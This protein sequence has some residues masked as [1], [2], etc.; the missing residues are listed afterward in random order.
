MAVSGRP[1]VLAGPFREA[2]FPPPGS[3]HRAAGVSGFPQSEGSQREQGRNCNAFYD[4][5]SEVTIHH[6]HH[7]LYIRNKQITTSEEGGSLPEGRIMGECVDVFLNHHKGSFRLSFRDSD[8]QV[9]IPLR[10]LIHIV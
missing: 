9:R 1:Q 3:F 7:I 10:P 8:V 2:L 4:L 6:F 5:P